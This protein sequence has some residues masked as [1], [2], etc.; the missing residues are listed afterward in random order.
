M[1]Q[2]VEAIYENGV[3]RPLE[4][5]DLQ[6]SQRVS[7]TVGSPKSDDWG[8][9]MQWLEEARAE[10]AQMTDIPSIEEIQQMLSII[11]GSLSED[12]AAEREDR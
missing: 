2:H 12:L 3:L 11:P 5:L 6:D 9:D 7:I 8:R 1:V 4:P 10:V